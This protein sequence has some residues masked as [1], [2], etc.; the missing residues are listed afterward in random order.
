MVARVSAGPLRGLHILVV[1]DDTTV[2]RVLATILAHGGAL[3]TEADSS[4]A[5]ARSFERV[6][7]ESIVCALDLGSGRDAHDLLH[8]IRGMGSDRARHVP[9]VAIARGPDR[10][11]LDEALEAGFAGY[12]KAPFEPGQLFG[13]IADVADAHPRQQPQE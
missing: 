9:I 4:A 6:I 2:R 10:H 8:R 13:L 7:P 3:V 12:M 1:D 11:S 5:A